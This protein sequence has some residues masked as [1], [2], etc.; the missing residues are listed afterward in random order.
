MVGRTDGRTDKLMDSQMDGWMD[1][2]TNGW[3]DRKSPHSTGLRPLSGPLPKKQ[4]PKGIKWSVVPL[5]CST[6]LDFHGGKQGSG[7]DRRQNP[8]E[9]GDFPSIYFPSV[10]PSVHPSACPSIHPSICPS[11]RSPLEGPR[12]RQAGLRPSRSGLRASQAGLR[13][14][15]PGLRGSEAC[16]AGSEA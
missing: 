13:A 6:V 3:T 15:Q 10:R 11:V 4:S 1:G 8:V 2:R 14:S 16:L 9:W 7:P 5:P 12:A